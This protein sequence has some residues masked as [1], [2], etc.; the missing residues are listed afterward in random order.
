[1]KAMT[2]ADLREALAG[3]PQDAPVGRYQFHHA[4]FKGRGGTEVRFFP[5]T[6]ASLD[7]KDGRVGLNFGQ[8]EARNDKPEED[9]TDA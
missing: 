6:L 1:M 9:E 3:L 2:V 8:G 7:E 4:K 5:V